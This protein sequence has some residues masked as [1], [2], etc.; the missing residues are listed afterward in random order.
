MRFLT[1]PRASA[2]I[3]LVL[4]AGALLVASTTTFDLVRYVQLQGWAERAVVSVADYASRDENVDCSE[5][6]AL[7]EFVKSEMLGEDSFGLLALTAATGDATEAGGFVEDWTWDPP[8]MLGPEDPPDRIEQCRVGLAARRAST[9]EALAMADGEGV[10]I[11]QLCLSP[12]AG[13]LLLPAWLQN[14]M[15]TAIYRYHVLPVRGATPVQVCV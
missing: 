6:Q 11:A 5:V 2:G 12:D 8:F 14:I 3:Q 9:L 4:V 10:V 1:E 7:A 13:R 15:T